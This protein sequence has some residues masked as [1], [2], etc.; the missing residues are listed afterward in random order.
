MTAKRLTDVQRDLVENHLGLAKSLALKYAQKHRGRL[1]YEEA[2][3]G[4]ALGLIASA[5]R[6][7]ASKGRFA[8]SAYARTSGQIVDDL[9]NKSRWFANSR[10]TVKGV[11]VNPF[12]E[13]S[14]GVGNEVKIKARAE[15]DLVEQSDTVD[16]MLDGLS[17]R[18][19]F[20]VSRMVID[21]ADAKTVASEVGM[22]EATVWRDKK[23]A[24]AKLRTKHGKRT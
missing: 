20:V 24:L 1:T 2:L 7:E 13:D 9:R 23:L 8:T 22:T 11:F 3:S 15:L 19:K 18:E 5:S 4:A 6:Y 12:G 14:D 17:D 21:G 16:A 10:K